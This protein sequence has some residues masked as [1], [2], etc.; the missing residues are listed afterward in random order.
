MATKEY[1]GRHEII[2]QMLRT[3]RDNGSEGVPKTLFM[4][5]SFL[6]HAQLKEYLSFLVENGLLE[7]LS[8]SSRNSRERTIYKITEKGLRFLHVINEIK[9]LTGPENIS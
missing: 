2:A 6:S 7:E 8:M 3:A 1:R 9:S 5:K 4:Y